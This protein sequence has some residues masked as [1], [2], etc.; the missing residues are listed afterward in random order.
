MKAAVDGVKDETRKM[1]DGREKVGK[2]M[3]GWRERVEGRWEDL[4]KWRNE[5][6]SRWEELSDGVKERFDGLDEWKERVELKEK[7]RMTE[8]GEIRTEM[9]EL[10]E[11]MGMCCYFYLSTVPMLGSDISTFSR[12][13]QEI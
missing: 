13:S 5:V 6:D 12:Y 10:R 2:E 1:G 3:E 8:V 11:G 9:R 7:E 4:G